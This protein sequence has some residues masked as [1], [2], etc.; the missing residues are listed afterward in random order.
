M[1]YAQ[2]LEAKQALVD[3]LFKGECEK[4]SKAF[5]KLCVG[6]T[7]EELPRDLIDKWRSGFMK[8]GDMLEK[9][10][11]LIEADFRESSMSWGHTDDDG[12]GTGSEASSSGLENS[13]EHSESV[14][15]GK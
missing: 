10:Q 7:K 5:W 8:T 9:V 11:D 13:G 4:H 2:A 12:C 1:N 14:A 3:I 15:V 6:F